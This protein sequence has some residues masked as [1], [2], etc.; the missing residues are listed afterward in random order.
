MRLRTFHAADTDPLIELWRRCGLTRPWND[1]RADI[2]RAHEHDAATIFLVTDESGIIGSVMCGY[3]GH[4]GWVYYLASDPDHQ[5]KG[6]GKQLMT[7][8]E[9][10]LRDRGCPKIELMVRSTN[11][12]AIGFYDAIGYQPQDVT[13]QAKWLIETPD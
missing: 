2:G 11:S 9:D 6:I 7:A 8:A 10:W 13:V 1:P 3:D 5:G 12:A 4:R